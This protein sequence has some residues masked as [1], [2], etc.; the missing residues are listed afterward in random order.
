MP[1]RQR[2]PHPPLPTNPADRYLEAK[3][4]LEVLADDLLDY[5]HLNV[6]NSVF[7]KRVDEYFAEIDFSMTEG[8][9]EESVK[10]VKTVESLGKMIRETETTKTRDFLAFYKSIVAFME[11]L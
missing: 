11:S 10:L 3:M 2:T 8:F 7:R 6:Y 9:S 5:D 1:R 4:F